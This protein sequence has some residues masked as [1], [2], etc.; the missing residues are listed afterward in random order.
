MPADP[1][2][3]VTVTLHLSSSASLPSLPLPLVLSPS[4][5]VT[6]SNFLGLLPRYVGVPF[7]RVIK[8]F[9]MQGGDVVSADGRGCVSHESAGG[10]RG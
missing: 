1:Q 4:T 7:H 3:P 2:L 6:R 9:M 5:P 8:G 10:G